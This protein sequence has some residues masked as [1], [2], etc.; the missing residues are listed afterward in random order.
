FAET[1]WFQIKGFAVPPISRNGERPPQGGFEEIIMG[2]PFTSTHIY[3]ITDTFDDR[4][5]GKI[6]G[7]YSKH[8]GV[9]GL[10]DAGYTLTPA[11]NT[12][13][14]GISVSEFITNTERP[15]VLVIAVNCAGPD[16]DKGTD[17][18]VRNDFFCAQLRDNVVVCGTSNGVEF[19]Y[20]KNRIERLYRL[21]N[22]NDRKSQFRSLEILPEHTLLFSD[23]ERR[24]N[25][26]ASGILKEE[27]VDLIV[28]SVPSVTH[29]HEIDNFRNVKLVPS[30][31]DL[32]LL[33]RLDGKS[34]DFE[35]GA[36]SLEVTPRQ[37]ATGAAHKAL[38]EPTLFRAELGTNVAALRSSSRRLL[39]SREA[40]VESAIPIIATMRRVPAETPPNYEV[41]IIGAPVWLKPAPTRLAA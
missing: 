15:D 6:D 13:D 33:R 37:A 34:I 10:R 18:N 20:V 28:P 5:K 36:T 29:V 8:R 17:D 30:E 11:L 19:S 38:V 1:A 41:P 25:L 24:A 35:F 2:V 32:E 14:I 16:N 26:I 39:G 12:I 3:H 4:A 22:T 27:D 7:A 40:E 21:T 23:P 31:D 9:I